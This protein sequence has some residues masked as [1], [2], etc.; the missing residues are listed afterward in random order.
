MTLY[1][2]PDRIAGPLPDHDIAIV[3]ASDSEECRDALR[4]IDRGRARAGRGR[5]SI[6]R[7]WSQSRSRQAASLARRNR[8]PGDS[9]DD[10]RRTR[11]II[12]AVASALERGDLS[13]PTLLS[14]HRQAARIACRG[15][16]C[17]AR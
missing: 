11:A 10:R 15:G 4:K 14:R 5:C 6:R 12:G 13:R 9:G 7:I 1:V 8:W 16:S 3:I 17:Q 2:I